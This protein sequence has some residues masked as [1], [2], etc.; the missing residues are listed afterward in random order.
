MVQNT[1]SSVYHYRYHCAT[2]T[3]ARTL[4]TLLPC[5]SVPII[6][7]IVSFLFFF[8][9]FFLL[10][11]IICLRFYC[12]CYWFFFLC[13]VFRHTD[14]AHDYILN[15]RSILRPRSPVRSTPSG[16]SKPCP[17]SASNTRRTASCPRSTGP[18]TKIPETKQK[19]QIKTRVS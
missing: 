6:S 10:L 16:T 13:T 3:R 5:V 18:N 15:L 14:Y 7:H 2:M 1:S 8:F 17:G 11:F 9:L 12:C 4:L 19:K